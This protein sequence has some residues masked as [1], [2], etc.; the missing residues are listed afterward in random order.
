[1]LELKHIYK[2]F[3]DRVIFNDLS[4]TFP[5]CGMIGIQGESG[6]GKSTLLYMIGM[7]DN[8][9]EGEVLWNGD[10]IVDRKQFIREHV[11]LMMQNYDLISSLT[12]KENI[13]LP[14]LTSDKTYTSSAF[15]KIT[16]QLG[17]SHLLS[18]YPSELSGG[19]KKRVSIAKALL[20]QSSLLLCDEPTGAVHQK[21]AQDIMRLLKIF[22]K[23]SLVIVVSHDP[24]L[25]EQFCD[26]ILTLKDGQLKGDI[27]NYSQKNVQN[28]HRRK[29]PL[30]FYPMRQF[31]FQRNKLV[32]LFLFQWIVIVA[33][34]LIVTAI[35]GVFD[36]IDR[37]EKTSV[38]LNVMSIEKKDGE[39]FDDLIYFENTVDVQYQYHLEQF[40]CQS[41]LQDVSCVFHFLPQQT[42]HISLKQGRFPSRSEEV[43]VTSSLYEQLSEKTLLHVSYLDYVKDFEIVGII[44]DDFFTMNEVYCLR[45]LQDEIPFLKNDYSLWIEAKQ[46]QSQHI[47]QQLSKRYFTYS[48]VHERVDNY[49]TLLSYIKMIAVVF[50]GV[51]L[52]ISLLLIAIVESII[53]FE[54]KHDV[55]YL[56][57]LGLSYQR[58]FVLSL[59]EALFLG[60]LIAGGGIFISVIVYYYVNYVLQIKQIFS[61]ELVLKPLLIGKYD[62]FL[63][64]GICYMMMSVLASLV[65]TLK[66]MKTDII[67]ILREE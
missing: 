6:C 67:S 56:L 26:C 14:C 54:R 62:V 32:F 19:Q 45:S 49:Q 22:S 52:F 37:S 57:S 2:K 61:F 20:K 53:Y 44:T 4:I 17:L 1:M 29:L 8:C 27:K 39:P 46:G 66:V 35:N 40:V 21:Q 55:A 38:S 36:A 5:D 18:R 42:E 25:L 28:S 13:I 51:S 10:K 24:Y 3:E 63:M 23:Q 59:I 16:T 9:F 11:S 43:I 58:L 34:F 65:P 48:D 64:I 41:Q 33:F 15:K 60:V 12:V 7:L 47:Y 50:I 31:L 30:W